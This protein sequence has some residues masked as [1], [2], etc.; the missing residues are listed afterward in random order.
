MARPNDRAIRIETPQSTSQHYG[1]SAYIFK[2]ACA[3]L[4]GP[5]TGNKPVLSMM[6]F[7]P[8]IVRRQ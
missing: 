8:G 5:D 1:R 2:Y 3:L 4:T 7:A 6:A